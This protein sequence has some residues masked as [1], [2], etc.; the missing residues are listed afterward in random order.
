[1]NK[2]L[3]LDQVKACISAIGWNA[4]LDVAAL[5]SWKALELFLISRDKLPSRLEDVDT[6]VLGDFIQNHSKRVPD[7]E[8]LLIQLATLR[9]ILLR[10]GHS[11]EP[12]ATLSVP[13][14]RRR[15]GNDKHG[16]YRFEKYLDNEAK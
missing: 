11:V 14:K 10:S 16:R 12:L 6:T 5:D 3:I 9:M 15:L 8:Y 13:I 4:T 7:V 1:M 2:T